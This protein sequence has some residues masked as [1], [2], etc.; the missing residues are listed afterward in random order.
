MSK[1]GPVILIDDDQDDEE[2]F[3]T[4]LKE[5]K[6]ENEFIWFSN[7]ADAL[8]FLQEMTGQPFVIFCDVNMPKQSGLEFKREIDDHPLLRKKSIPFIF[9]STS[10]DKKLVTEAYNQTTIQGFF[11]KEHSYTAILAKLKAII[12]YWMICE[13]PSNY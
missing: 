8:V 4:A 2:I 3:R 12:D 9:Y 5:L 1:T 6:V 7:T 10:A 11:R 13:H